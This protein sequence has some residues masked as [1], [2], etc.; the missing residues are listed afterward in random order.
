MFNKPILFLIFNREEHSSKVFDV[1]RDIKPRQLYI[2]ADGP[3]A[4]ISGEAKVCKQVRESI[5]NKIDWDCEIHTLFRQS[6]IGCGLAVSSAISWFFENEE[7]GI[8]LED[9]CLPDKTFFKYCSELLDQHRFN[10][11]ISIISGCNFDQNQTNHNSNSSYFYSKI[12]YTWG[13]ATWKR[14]WEGY[15]YNIEKWNKINRR[16]FLKWLFDEIEFQNFWEKV[17]NDV[18]GGQK[19]T[20]DYQ[21]FFHCFS[22]KQL[23]IVPSVNLVTNIGHDQSATHT[24]NSES[25]QSKFPIIPIKFPLIHGTDISQNREYDILLQENCFGRIPHISFKKRVYRF[26]KKKFK[27]K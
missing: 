13:W 19:T 3:R 1:I 22:Q 25:L 17:F 9:D 23:A 21:F 4:S 5:I 18:Y 6:N 27:M 20:W 24:F 7:E 11:S 14:T 26:I 2:A 8:I 10:S 12:P 16:A 15:D